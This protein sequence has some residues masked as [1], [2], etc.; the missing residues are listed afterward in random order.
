MTIKHSCA[1]RNGFVAIA[2]ARVVLASLFMTI[3]TGDPLLVA[4]VA[5]STTLGGMYEMRSLS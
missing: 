1:V 4:F 2:S 3:M 5:L